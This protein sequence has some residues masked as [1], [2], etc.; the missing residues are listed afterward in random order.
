MPAC[1]V[2]GV[3]EMACNVLLAG[4]G[5]LPGLEA[6]K[7]PECLRWLCS[8]P[9][10]STATHPH[11]PGTAANSWRQAG[12]EPGLYAPWRYGHRQLQLAQILLFLQRW[13]EE[14]KSACLCFNLDTP[15]SLR[16]TLTAYRGKIGSKL[17]HFTRWQEGNVLVQFGRKY[18]SV[19][20]T[21][22]L[23]QKE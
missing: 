21:F 15:S 5:H 22:S 10:P 14:R 18:M 11:Q 16:S 20:F 19:Y 23:L 8:T 12:W 2:L 1:C 3:W 7:D 9:W 13:R 17:S 6:A 4:R